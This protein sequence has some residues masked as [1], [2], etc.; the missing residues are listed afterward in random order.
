MRAAERQRA[1]LRRLNDDL[2]PADVTDRGRNARGDEGAG[3]DGRHG[4]PV[5]DQP[6]IG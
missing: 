3:A 1:L 4:K 5:R 2:R 6:F